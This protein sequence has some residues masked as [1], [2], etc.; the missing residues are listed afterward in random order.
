M[1]I[2]TR[3]ERRTVG[4]VY[5]FVPAQQLQC[6]LDDGHE[7]DHYDPTY[8]LAWPDELPPPVP[9]TSKLIQPPPAGWTP[10]DYEYWAGY[11]A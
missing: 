7:G 5:G 11:S 2:C 4:T 10:D 6:D 1:T 3:T 8:F 9:T